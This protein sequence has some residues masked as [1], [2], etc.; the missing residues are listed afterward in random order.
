MLDVWTFNGH[1]Q[2]LQIDNVWTA[3]E[4]ANDVGFI[5]IALAALLV[6]HSWISY[7]TYIQL[8]VYIH[9]YIYSHTYTCEG[10]W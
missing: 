1:A 5:G 4:A 2:D 8:Y 7:E 10:K 9:V 3:V 6:V